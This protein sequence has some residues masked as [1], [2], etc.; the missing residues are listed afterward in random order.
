MATTQREMADLRSAAQPLAT[1]GRMLS[2][3]SAVGERFLDAVHA[4]DS[5]AVATVFEQM[6][7]RGVEHRREQSEIVT[8]ALHKE[9][10]AYQPN[11][12][13]AIEIVIVIDGKP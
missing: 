13:W 4:G 11:D 5:K 12:R 9:V 2:T 3:D 7:V 1:A 10:L 6:G 8:K